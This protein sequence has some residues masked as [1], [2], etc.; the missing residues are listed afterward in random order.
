[1]QNDKKRK[2]SRNGFDAFDPELFKAPPASA[3]PVYAWV[4]NDTITPEGI[5]SQLDDFERAG[6]K[7]IYVLAEPKN[8]RPEK[9]LTPLEPDYLSDEYVRL[10]TLAYSYAVGTRINAG[11]SA[12]T[13]TDL[14]EYIAAEYLP[15]DNFVN[16]IDE[17]AVDAFLDITFGAMK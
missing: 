8:F 9:Q 5:R 17:K 1:M 16:L 12:D 4:W 2:L 7:G 6:I 10:L 14:T 15:N 13:D 11:F 3:Y